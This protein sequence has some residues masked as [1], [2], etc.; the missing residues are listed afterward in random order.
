MFRTRITPRNDKISKQKHI[1]LWIRGNV[2]FSVLLSL[3]FS[4]KLTNHLTAFKDPLQDQGAA[5]GRLFFISCSQPQEAGA[6][7]GGNSAQIFPDRI[8]ISSP[9]WG[10][11]IDLT[12]GAPSVW[13][14][15]WKMT[16]TNAPWEIWPCLWASCWQR[17]IWHWLRAFLWRTPAPA[18]SS[19]LKWLW[20]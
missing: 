20:G 18:P 8:H 14:H 2:F 10:K 16:S 1:K 9:A 11:T 7:G 13:T 12:D 6:G 3:P 4:L 5:V 17:R 15:R 19:N